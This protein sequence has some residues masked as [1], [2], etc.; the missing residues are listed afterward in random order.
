M[1]K[2]TLILLLGIFSS[3]VFAGT[4]QSVNPADYGL[5]VLKEQLAE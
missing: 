3:S 1:K 4:S 2:A 5:D